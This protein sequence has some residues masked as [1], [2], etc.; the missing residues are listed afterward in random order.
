MNRPIKKLARALLIVLILSVS[1]AALPYVGL[2]YQPLA[3][4][5]LRLNSILYHDGCPDYDHNGIVE[6]YDI[7]E[8]AL[9][10]LLTAANPDPDQNPLT[11]NYGPQYDLRFDGVI[12]MRDIMEA[13][14]DFGEFCDD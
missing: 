7:G 2:P 10:W 12:N 9:R 8:V 3:V 1:L 11:P 14:E 4:T 6:A 13:A 5:A